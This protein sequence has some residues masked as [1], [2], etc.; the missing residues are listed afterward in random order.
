[1]R[2]L[3]TI[4]ATLLIATGICY[5]Q[6]KLSRFNDGK[7]AF[8]FKYDPSMAECE[9][10]R[11]NIKKGVRSADHKIMLLIA[12]FDQSN[13]VAEIAADNLTLKDVFESDEGLSL[14]MFGSGKDDPNNPYR[15]KITELT[16]GFTIDGFDACFVSTEMTIKRLGNTYRLFDDSYVFIYNDKFFTISSGGIDP[17]VRGAAKKHLDISAG[18][19]ALNNKWLP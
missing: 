12:Y 9:V 19:F 6:L 18:T 1:M 8:S 7:I 2:Y 11:P 3:T 13:L 5:G 17:S 10:Q 4:V 15:P 14:L 16:R